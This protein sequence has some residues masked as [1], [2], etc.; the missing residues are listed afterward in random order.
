[1][2]INLKGFTL[3]ELLVV[4]AIIA[5]LAAILFPV[6]AQAR[7]KARQASCLSC[8]KQIGVG[9]QLYVD[10][11]DETFPGIAAWGIPSTTGIIGYMQANVYC[12]PVTTLYP[13][14]KNKNMFCCPSSPS[15]AD[16]LTVWNY[17]TGVTGETQNNGTSPGMGSS[18]VFNG[19]AYNYTSMAEIGSTGDLIFCCEHN[20]ARSWTGAGVYPSTTNIMPSPNYTGSAYE[21]GR[22]STFINCGILPKWNGQAPHNG[23]QNVTFAD[24]H[25]KYMKT[26][27]ITWRNLGVVPNSGETPDTP[28][29]HNDD[30]MANYNAGFLTARAAQLN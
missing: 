27:S 9:L 18:Y 19:V 1:M 2:K 23:G 30:D 17:P 24:S 4:I 13:Y 3:I 26:G 22:A 28:V 21:G 20:T 12:N 5:I 11:Y 7:E 10:D 14:I 25:A 6:F 29:P 16:L 8:M 15:R